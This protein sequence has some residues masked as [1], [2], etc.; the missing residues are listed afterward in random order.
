MGKTYKE[1]YPGSKLSE[2]AKY[3]K[4]SKKSKKVQKMT[5]YDRKKASC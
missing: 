3:Y 4:S 1:C 5:P 2:E